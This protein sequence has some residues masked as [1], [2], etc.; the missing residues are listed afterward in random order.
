MEPKH[1]SDGENEYRLH[2]RNA[3]LSNPE[4]FKEYTRVLR[5]KA[6][7]G[8]QT[9]GRGALVV[10]DNGSEGV[11]VYVPAEVADMQ[12]GVDTSKLCHDYDPDR[13]WIMVGITNGR[14]FPIVM[15]F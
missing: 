10:V 1:I 3:S 12:F 14:S 13:E 7:E 5:E 15:L 4:E 9:L 2:L 8:F 11:H 6:R